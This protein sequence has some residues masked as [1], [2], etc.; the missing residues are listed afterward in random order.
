MFRKAAWL[1]L[2]SFFCE[3]AMKATP[4]APWRTS[5]RVALWITWPGT[6]KS[7]IRTCRPLPTANESGSRSKKSV[8]SSRVSSVIRRP[9]VSGETSRWIACRFVV[10]PLSAGP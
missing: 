4:S 3:S 2:V 10:F 9:E 7:L 5:R 8:R 1:A 6:V